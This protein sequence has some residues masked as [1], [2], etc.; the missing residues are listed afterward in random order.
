[1]P[2]SQS[3]DRRREQ[4]GHTCPNQPVDATSIS[5]LVMAKGPVKHGQCVYTAL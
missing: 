5:I 1:M 4:R 2:G 3:A